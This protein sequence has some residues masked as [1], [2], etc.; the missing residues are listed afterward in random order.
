MTG[1]HYTSYKKQAVSLG[2]NSHLSSY[3]SLPFMEPE[4]T[5]SYS[6]QP[7]H[8]SSSKPAE[9]SPYFDTIFT[10]S[11]ILILSFHLHIY[12]KTTANKTIEDSKIRLIFIRE[13]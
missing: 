9:P 4:L 8:G 10:E 12:N 1:C 2:T 3:N 7:R 13:I 5:Q 6:Q 11:Q